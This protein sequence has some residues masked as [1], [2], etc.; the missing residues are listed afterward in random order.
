MANQVIGLDV[1]IKVA[2]ALAELRKLSPG[3]DKEAK[4]IAGSLSKAL[5]DAEK[6]AAK[7][8]A[9]MKEVA[10]KTSS[11]ADKAGTAGANV[12]KLAGALSLVNPAAAGVAGNIADMADVV[13]V[14]GVASEALGVSLASIATIAAPVAL[15]IGAL[16]LAYREY[17]AELQVSLDKEAESVRQMGIHGDLSAKVKADRQ[18]LAIA[19]G[20]LSQATVDAEAIEADYAARLDKTT[21]TDQ[22][23]I[24]QA[25]AAIVAR[26]KYGSQANIL[27]AA[28][29]EKDIKRLDARIARTKQESDMGKEAALD[30]IKV[31]EA[32]AQGDRNVAANQKAAAEASRDRAQAEAEAKAAI[33]AATAANQQYVGTLRDIDDIGKQALTS[34]MDAYERLAETAQEKLDDIDQKGRQA[35]AQAIAAGADAGKADASVAKRTAAAK[36]AVNVEYY[37]NLDKLRADDAAKAETAAQA[38]IDKAEEAR[39]AK[40]QDG[41]DIAQQSA[42]L[43]IQGIEAVAKANEDAS[44]R[45]ADQADKLQAQLIAGD[46]Y[47]T[48]SQ[49]KELQKRIEDHRRS[50]RA[51]FATAKAARIAEATITTAMAVVNALNDGLATGGPAGLIIGP[52]AAVAA[53]VAGGIQIAAIAA[54]QPS[55][56]QGYA[57][58]ERSARLL[59][60]EAVLSPAATAALGSGNIAAA[61]AGIMGGGRQASTPVVFRH[62][63]FRPFIKDFLTQPSALSTA[64]NAGK[65][66]GHRARN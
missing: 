35:V 46:S 23:R 39:A 52:V 59:T 57:P 18:A 40:L 47:Y 9:A 41:K 49:K 1:E 66:V 12:Q 62:Q 43:A 29:A 22:N 56:H 17:N 34:Q 14:A 13:E 44:Q 45:E 11:V 37:A 5:K 58:D 51:A 31:D 20:T 42:T 33:Q 26:D 19:T 55:F 6:Q 63:T 61:N 60:S 3:A 7:T 32:R 50:A 38:E 2:N 25:Q 16:Y 54:E 4:A 28:Q 8:G 30:M 36:D 53:G 21:K 24:A 27:A 64:L 15:A 65:I 10:V 48:D